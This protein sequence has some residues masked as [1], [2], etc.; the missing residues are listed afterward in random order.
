MLVVWVVEAEGNFQVFLE[1]RSEEDIV[2]NSA[3]SSP[4]VAL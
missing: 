4:V 3:G 1:Y 2:P